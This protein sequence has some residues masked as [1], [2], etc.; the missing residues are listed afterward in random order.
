MQ[1]FRS[2]ICRVN[3]AA[4]LRRVLSGQR[5]SLADELARNR[6]TLVGS[7]SRA[8]EQLHWKDFESLV[9]MVFRHAGWKRIGILG[10]QVKSY[11]LALHEPVTGER[12]LVQVKSR[13]SLADL[14]TSIKDIASDDYRRIFYAVHSPE[15][16]LAQ[17]ED[18]PE[19][20][21]LVAPR[22]LAELSIDAGL[23][24]WLEEKVA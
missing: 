13:A 15:K 7:V 14:Y 1:G 20:V 5:S 21:D 19:H 11:D 12:F 24:G 17:A 10:Q 4:L 9:D 2:T 18:L 8:I 23:L 22:R 3:E 16:D 6:E